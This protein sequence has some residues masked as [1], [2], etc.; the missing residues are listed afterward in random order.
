MKK[1][2][3]VVC[4]CFFS[5]AVLAKS[6]KEK[7]LHKQN[8]TS[9][10][11]SSTL[12]RVGGNYVVR[13]INRTDN[14]VVVVFESVVKNGHADLI[15]LESDHIHIGIEEGQTLR[16][17]AEVSSS[18]DK[19]VDASQV[20]LFIPQA[21]GSVPVW[22]LSKEGRKKS[23]QGSSYLEMHDPRSDYAIL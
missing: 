7:S 15:R 17:S 2:L 13:E 21:E 20:L 8:G 12:K 16:I 11:N 23:L 6:E 4:S 5:V 22:L 18:T 3:I 1:I 14:S 10:D 9:F 19:E